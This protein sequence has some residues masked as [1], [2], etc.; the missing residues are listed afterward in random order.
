MP[1]IRWVQKAFFGIDKPKAGPETLLGKM[2]TIRSNFTI[3]DQ[4]KGLEGFV[5]IDGESWKARSFA[6]ESELRTGAVVR[7]AERQ[8]FEL[9][10]EPCNDA[11]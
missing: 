2:A 9:L 5:V 10:V 11:G 1:I 6:A 7:V 8:G 4:S 3:Q